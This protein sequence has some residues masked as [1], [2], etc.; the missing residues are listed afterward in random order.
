M[1]HV[2]LLLTAA[3]ILGSLAG[4]AK[5]GL[6][7]SAAAP[8]G[9]VTLRLALKKGDTFQT[10]TKVEVTAD[11]SSLAGQGTPEMK[12]QLAGPQTLTMTQVEKFEVTEV[13]DGVTTLKSTVT[14]VQASG[15]GIMGMQA[16]MMKAAKGTTNTVRY[17]ERNEPVDGGAS[18]VGMNV[19]FPEKP[20][21]AGDTWTSETEIQGQK[22]T[23][24]FKLERF[25][26]VG[27]VDC[28][29]ISTTFSEGS[30][31]RAKGPLLT[32]VDRNTGR[33]VK[34][35]GEVEMEQ[36]GIKMQLKVSMTT[37]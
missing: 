9:P 33:L 23:A 35:E 8:E 32:W 5:G 7:R 37:G 26:S 14:D 17:N 6:E 28:A 13:S 29:V 19:A 25:E 18:N 12:A 36:T 15:T 20:V 34:G 3:G 31:I 10:T 11:L 22:V 30:P 1:R 4:C 21:K 24:T 16:D 27:G 2:L